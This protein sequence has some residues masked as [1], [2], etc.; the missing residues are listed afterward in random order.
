M[1]RPA[2]VLLAALIAAIGLAACGGDS[3][4]T[5]AEYQEAFQPVNEEIQNLGQEVGDAIVNAKGKS[6]ADLAAQFKDLATRTTAA[7]TSVGDLEPPDDEAI[8]KDQDALEAALNQGARDLTS[9]ASAAEA[10]NAKTAAAAVAKLAA[11]SDDIRKPRERIEK[12]LASEGGESE[13]T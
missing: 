4:P 12:A 1:R 8:Q 6:D 5:K 2:L 3:A 13:Q 11:D 9:I 7:A 10:G